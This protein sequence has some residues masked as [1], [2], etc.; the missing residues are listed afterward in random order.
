MAGI[1]RLRRLQLGKEST[2]GT[3]VAA[4]T[5]WR[6]E[7][8]GLDDQRK[9]EMIE[10]MVGLINGADRT[11]VVEL[12]AA[13]EG[14]ETP[15]TFEQFGYILA[16]SLGGPTSGSADG[17]GSDYIYTTN[18]PTTAQPTATPY[19]LQGGDDYEVERAEYVLCTKWGVTTQR[20]ATAKLS[21]STFFGRQV[22]Y[23]GTGFS[24]A[25]I[26]SVLEEAISNK[27]KVYLDAVSGSYRTTQ[28]S[29]SIVACEIS[30]ESMWQ[31][32]FT[33][34]G[35]LY[36]TT[37]IFAGYKL[38][39]KLTYLHDAAS[40]GNTGAKKTFRDQTPKLLSID[41]EGGTVT[42][43]GTTYNTKH[44]IFNLPIKFTK[45]SVLED[46]DGVD[47]VSFDWESRYNATKGD[48]GQIIVVNELASLP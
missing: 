30:C 46:S 6:G 9:V 7:V 31:P 40:N 16:M 41:L 44:V 43:A 22:A 29:S 25:S 20:G 28:V 36:Y 15:L 3:A 23:L 1:K 11:R 17:A 42:S 45:V 32:V 8:T 4:T 5:R 37:A 27:G 13:Y 2:P 19:T 10:E 21:S 26:P 14:A 38:S 48:A 39:G 12:M 24:A 35:Q 47:I 34:D 33:M 18:L